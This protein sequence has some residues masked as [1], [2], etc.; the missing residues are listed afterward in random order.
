MGWVRMADGRLAR[1]D[2]RTAGW[3]WAATQ[4]GGP[5]LLLGLVPGLP[6]ALPHLEEAVYE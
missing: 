5:A 1:V 2:G 4:K 6:T 3:G